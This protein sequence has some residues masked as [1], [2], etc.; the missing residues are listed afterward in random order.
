M[1]IIRA[2]G[3]L[4]SAVTLFASSASAYAQHLVGGMG[5]P[6]QLGAFDTHAD[7]RTKHRNP[8]GKISSQARGPRDAARPETNV[9]YAKPTLPGRHLR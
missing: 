1:T 3:L 6:I 2:L 7:A 5:E 4:A 9:R 8:P